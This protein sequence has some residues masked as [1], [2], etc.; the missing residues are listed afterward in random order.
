MTV[1][2]WRGLTRK[3]ANADVAI[4]ADAEAFLELFVER[5]GDLAT[6]QPGVAR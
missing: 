6:R 4:E 2:D 3:A 1:A 5:V